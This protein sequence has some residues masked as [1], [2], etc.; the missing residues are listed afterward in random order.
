[1]WNPFR[2]KPA[3]VSFP[4]P[5]WPPIQALDSIDVLGNRHDGG[6]DLFI[7][8]SQPID[9]ST[10]TLESIRHKVETYLKAIDLKGFQEEMGHPPREKTTIV[11]A[12]DHLIHP[13]A[14]AVIE[15][16]QA[17]AAGQ[18]VRLEVRKLR[19]VVSA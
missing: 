7:I 2:A 5:E 18:G 4:T 11:I 16:C 15:Q 1:M 3:E 19:P 6:V 13:K 8:A 14:H 12:C 10:Q 17:S 9:S